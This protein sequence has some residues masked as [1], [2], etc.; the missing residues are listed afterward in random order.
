MRSAPRLPDTLH[1]RNANVQQQSDMERKFWN[2]FKE[3]VSEWNP[4]MD[5][6]GAVRSTFFEDAKLHVDGVMDAAEARCP[7]RARVRELLDM[8]FAPMVAAEVG[9][10]TLDLQPVR[11]LVAALVQTSARH[12]MHGV[13]DPPG[14]MACAIGKNGCEVCR[15]GFPARH[16]RWL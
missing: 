10:G 16:V 14:H 3:L 2:F 8:V 13:D 12:T 5:A 9:G 4:V 6:G 1:P 7:E 15:Y 11:R